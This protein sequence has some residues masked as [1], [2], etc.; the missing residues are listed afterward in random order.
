MYCIN[1]EVVEVLMEFFNKSGS[2]KI[3]ELQ[4]YITS[5]ITN[6]SIQNELVFTNIFSF[7]DFIKVIHNVFAVCTDKFLLLKIKREN[8][9]KSDSLT[10]FKMNLLTNYTHTNINFQD[11]PKLLLQLFKTNI[12]KIY[13][14]NT[15]ELDSFVLSLKEI[16]SNLE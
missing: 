14:F 6:S 10:N 3:T 1:K 9:T 4:N 16:Y 2:Y 13:E 15:E 7:S 11:E 5:K 12:K 8:N